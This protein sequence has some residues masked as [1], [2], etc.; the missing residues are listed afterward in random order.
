MVAVTVLACRFKVLWRNRDLVWSRMDDSPQKFFI[1]A[2]EESVRVCQNLAVIT[3]DKALLT[4]YLIYPSTSPRPPP[5]S[6]SLSLSH[7]LFPPS[8]PQDI[9]GYSLPSQPLGSLGQPLPFP[10]WQPSSVCTTSGCVGTSLVTK[11]TAYCI[12]SLPSFSLYAGGC[13]CMCVCVFLCTY[14][15]GQRTVPFL[16]PFCI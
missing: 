3:L 2:E 16:F 11:Y 15:G 1:P 10:P 6:F 12:Y 4:F 14:L 13:M 5:L 7:F 8:S 9:I